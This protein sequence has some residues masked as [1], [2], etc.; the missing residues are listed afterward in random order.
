MARIW[1]SVQGGI[2]VGKRYGGSCDTLL[3]VVNVYVL[4]S[5]VVAEK[6]R[7]VLVANKRQILVPSTTPSM[8]NW[9]Q[10]VIFSLPIYLT[11][12]AY[13]KTSC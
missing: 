12:L 11:S 9:I 8:N 10:H 2:G 7:V 1:K 4:D 3:E 5:E 6:E 13:F